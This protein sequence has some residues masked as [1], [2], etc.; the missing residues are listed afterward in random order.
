MDSSWEG[1]PPAGP[2]IWLQSARASAHSARS[3][4][5]LRDGTHLRT[6]QLFRP[7]ES[8]EA[9]RLR[10]QQCR[11]VLHRKPSG[12]QPH[13]FEI[14]VF[15][16]RWNP[17]SDTHVMHVSCRLMQGKATCGEFMDDSPED[18][19]ARVAVAAPLLYCRS[20]RATCRYEVLSLRPLCCPATCSAAGYERTEGES[21]CRQ[22]G[23]RNV[24]SYLAIDH[25]QL[26]D[27]LP[28]F[29]LLKLDAVIV[30]IAN[31]RTQDR[32]DDEVPPG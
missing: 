13:I 28:D 5:M 20:A 29:R 30:I 27:A 32:T 6:P 14:A 2:E 1:R 18:A 22:S 17:V 21:R 8:R 15:R 24:F 19:P 23:L 31:A 16:T 10:F 9:L 26:G 3:K 25:S 4:P 11:L 7:K 12:M